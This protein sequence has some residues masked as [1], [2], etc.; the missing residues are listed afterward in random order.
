MLPHWHCIAAALSRP[1]AL[2]AHK[3]TMHTSKGDASTCSAK[4]N[5]MRAAINCAGLSPLEACVA[6]FVT[7]AVELVG[8]LCLPSARFQA[9]ASSARLTQ[10]GTWV[11][12]PLL[13]EMYFTMALPHAGLPRGVVQAVAVLQAAARWIRCCTCLAF[14]VATR[15]ASFPAAWI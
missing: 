5:A 6:F 13:Q 15:E 14:H 8:G 1:D 10:H 3:C 7:L 11:A 9:V 2:P 4:Q 12:G